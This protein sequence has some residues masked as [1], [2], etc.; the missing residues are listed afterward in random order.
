MAAVGI[1]FSLIFTK[2]PSIFVLPLGYSRL[3]LKFLAR[4]IIF[5]VLAAIPLAAFLNPGWSQINVSVGSLAVILWVCQML[6]FLLA[7]L[8]LLLV[9]PLV[10]KRCGL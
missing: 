3:S 7:M 1:I 2:D 6:G 10:C 4:V 8:M 5:I 9:G